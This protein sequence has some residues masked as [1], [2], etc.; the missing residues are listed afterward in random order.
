MPINPPRTP[1]QKKALSYAKDRRNTYGENDKGARKAIPRRK[2][3]LNRKVRR[4]ANQN[5]GTAKC[6]TDETIEVVE[7][8]LRHDLDRVGGWE[9]SADTPLGEILGKTVRQKRI[10]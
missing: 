3:E 6:A 2:A 7:S 5:L 4:K 1:Q 10:R 8:S 9:K